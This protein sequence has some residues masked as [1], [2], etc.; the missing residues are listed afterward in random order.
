M[1]IKWYGHS[2]FVI[3][4]EGFQIT[5][6]P[7]DNCVGYR[8][9]N[10]IPDIITISHYHGDHADP[11][12]IKTAPVID[13]EVPWFKNS[14]VK[15]E[16][17]ESFHDENMGSERGENTIFSIT[18]N[19]GIN[20]IHLGDLGCEPPEKLYKIRNHILLAPFGGIYTIDGNK[21]V[22]IAR[23]LGSKVL[24]PMH[25]KTEKV[26]FH[27]MS[28]EDYDFKIHNE[29]ALEVDTLKEL[30]ESL[31]IISLKYE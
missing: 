28:L 15:I 23:E 3:E 4:H 30:P 13:N 18:L 5:T 17:I 1:I 31:K 25:Y 27:L 11:D 2:C 20:I 6:D 21:A 9:P 29:D 16:G 10:I 26:D 12:Y 19:N 7:F 14:K 24:I 22:K 8:L